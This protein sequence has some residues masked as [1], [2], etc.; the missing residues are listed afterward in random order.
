MEVK[1]YFRMLQRSWWVVVIATLTAV[2]AALVVSYLTRPIYQATSRFI[3]SPSPSLISGGSN[4]LNSLST[5][6]KRSIISTYAEVLNSPRIHSETYKLLGFTEAA[7]VNYSYNAVAL[8]DAN[9]VEFSVQGPDPKTDYLLANGIGQHAV[10]YVQSLYQV[11]DLTLLDPAGM[12]VDPISPKPLRDASVAFIVGLALGVV[13]A[14]IRELIRTPIESFIRRRNLDD[15]S[16]ALNR[17]AFE[18]ILADASFGS[19]KDFSL[20][21]VHLNG[22]A[23][24][25]NLLPQST[26]QNIFRYVTK[27]LEEQLRGND[28]VGRWSELDFI[29]LLTVT[30]GDA[31]LNTMGRVRTA[32]CKPISLDVSGEELH[33]DPQIGIAEY[34][35]DD[36]SQSM[37]KNIQWALAV[38]KIHD[39]IHLLKATQ[40]I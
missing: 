7:M 15:M 23:D 24:Y 27:T 8:P 11:Y 26:Q 37:I 1:L 5:L 13:L 19:S 31:A 25:V 18:Q 2:V 6:D 10:E 33:L 30:T 35:V 28:R 32:L 21:I 39:G 14:L 3:V 17:N 22:M 36:T 38:A 29:V 20:C 40:E 16:L 34:R 9:I 12:P 4:L